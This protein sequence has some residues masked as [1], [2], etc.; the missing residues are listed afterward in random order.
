MAHS[1]ICNIVTYAQAVCGDHRLLGI[2][3]G[4]H[5]LE[6]NEQLDKTA[7]FLKEHAP[8][9]LYPC[10]CVGLACKAK[11]MASLPVSEVG[12]GMTLEL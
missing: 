12:V 3:G 10:H 5:L 1:G 11:L 4:F 8:R 6:D 9:R 7:A 2:L